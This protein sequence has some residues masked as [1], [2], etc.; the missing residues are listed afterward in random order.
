[1]YRT[2]KGK[3]IPLHAM[4]APGGKEVQLPLILNL[5]TRWGWVVSIT[6]RP[7]FTP[8]ERTPVTHWIGGWVDH[9]AG[10]DAE[11]RG[12]I[13]CHCRGSNPVRR[14]K[15]TNICS[16][17]SPL[18]RE[19]FR[20]TSYSTEQ[21]VRKAW[22]IS[23]QLDHDNAWH[24]SV[25]GN[26]N[27]PRNWTEGS[28]VEIYR[29]DISR[30]YWYSALILRLLHRLKY[31]KNYVYIFIHV[32]YFKNRIIL[33]VVWWQRDQYDGLLTIHQNKF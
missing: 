7:R 29:W 4:E 24:S 16:H 21:H 14:A 31:K 33:F 9:R 15:G 12:K 18:S 10:L 13:L 25:H 27:S 22:E 11:A 6:P 5:C 17:E 8:G 23:L 30:V 26:A 2:N 28:R 32:I 3:V 20:W 19:F 1:M